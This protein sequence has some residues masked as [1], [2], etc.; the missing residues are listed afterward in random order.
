MPPFGAPVAVRAASV[1]DSR[2]EVRPEQP[3]TAAFDDEGY[4]PIF[5][6]SSALSTRKSRAAMTAPTTGATM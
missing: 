4:A 1:D 5:F 6:A 3:R 2:H